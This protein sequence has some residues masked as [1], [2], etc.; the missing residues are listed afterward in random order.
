MLSLLITTVNGDFKKTD[1]DLRTF[2]S[3]I[4]LLDGELD[5]FGPATAHTRSLLRQYTASAIAS[6]WPGEPPPAGEYPKALPD[7]SDIDALVLGDMLHQAETEI[8]HLQPQDAGAE[9]VQAACLTRIAALLDQR[10][11]LISEAH[12]SIT[13]AFFVMMLFWLSIVFL[14]FGMTAPPNAVAATSIIMVAL[15]V[16]GA[17]FVIMEQDG[18][19]DGL[20]QVASEPMRHAL[21]HLDRLPEVN[22]SR[23]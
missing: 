17:I 19:L 8:R 14:S 9:K 11:S 23:H 13:P 10:W 16:A 18:P 1:N 2:A 21:R 6:T 4:V 15:S 12:S 7:G 3:M 5:A 20:L 22:V